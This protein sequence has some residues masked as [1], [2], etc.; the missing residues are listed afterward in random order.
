MEQ[1]ITMTHVGN[2]DVAV[3]D[4]QVLEEDD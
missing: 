2:V 4:D 1:S 3:P